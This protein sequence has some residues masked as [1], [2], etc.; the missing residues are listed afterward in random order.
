MWVKT[1]TISMGL[2]DQLRDSRFCL[3]SRSLGQIDA[4]KSSPEPRCLVRCGLPVA[5]G[6]YQNTSTP[7]RVKC[8]QIWFVGTG[9]CKVL[10]PGVIPKDCASLEIQLSHTGKV[11]SRSS[12]LKP[13]Q[14]E[15]ADLSGRFEES[16]AFPR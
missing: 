15:R 2:E 8:F 3:P 7:Y 13:I 12:E 6:L 14:F 11:K 16:V 4:A 5:P 9:L 10:S 1:D